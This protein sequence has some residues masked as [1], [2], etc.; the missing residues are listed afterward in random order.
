MLGER[1]AGTFGMTSVPL[2][3]KKWKALQITGG[4]SV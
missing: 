1:S 4:A 2:W 3:T